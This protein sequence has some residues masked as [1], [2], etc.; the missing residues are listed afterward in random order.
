MDPRT[1]GPHPRKRSIEDVIEEAIED[2]LESKRLD[3]G[4]SSQTIEA[5]RIDLQQFTNLLPD[6][7]NDPSQILPEHLHAFIERLGTEGQRSSS[8]ARKMSALRQF[9]KFCCL[10]KGLEH[11]PAESLSS[12]QEGR[13]LPHFLSLEEVEALLTTTQVGLPYP[14]RLGPALQSRDR[15]MVTLL[16]ATGLRVSELVGL[17]LFQLDLPQGYLR[18]RGKGDKERIVPF[19]PVAGDLL[20]AYLETDRPALTPQEDAV[21]LNHRGRALTR[22]AFWKILKRLALASG[23]SSSLSP[24]VIRH[25]FATHLLQ[26]G[27]NLRSLQLILGHADLSTTQV[28]THITPEHLKEA[29]KKFHPR[30]E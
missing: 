25:S 29:H 12:P 21:F 11:N 23:L 18:V 4:A 2:F 16:Y 27:M 13:A 28:Y 5:Y 15:A 8:I 14:G 6:E 9:F 17:T 24:H 1:G 3:R 20:R 10:E 26:A 30:G 7:V 19:A 22:Q